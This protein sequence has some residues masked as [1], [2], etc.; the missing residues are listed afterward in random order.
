SWTVD[1]PSLTPDLILKNKIQRLRSDIKAWSTAQLAAQRL[2]YE[3]LTRNI[4]RW[5]LKAEMGLI[6]YDN[7][8]KQEE[9]IMELNGMERL[10]REDLNRNEG[11][12]RQSR[13]TKT[14]SFLT[15]YLETNSLS[16]PFVTCILI[17]YSLTLPTL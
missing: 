6:T 1:L 4:I 13:V 7:V 8:D 15:P 5:D 12:N 10:F 11:L 3:D 17:G 9:L 2:A 14:L 16:L